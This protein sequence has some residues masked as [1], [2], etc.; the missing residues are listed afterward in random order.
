VR[1][2]VL[3]LPSCRL[4]GLC[5]GV[6]IQVVDTRAWLSRCETVRYARDASGCTKA[7]LRGHTGISP[8]QFVVFLVRH[9]CG[10]SAALPELVALRLASRAD[11]GR[12][13]PS[14]GS[15]WHPPRFS[16]ASGVPPCD[17]RLAQ[18]APRSTDTRTTSLAIGGS[19]PAAAQPFFS[20]RRM[21]ARPKSPVASFSCSFNRSS[22]FPSSRR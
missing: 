12:S 15:T 19:H 2:S 5:V 6:Q 11:P 1:G 13:S 16:G 10:T 18:P 17:H 3:H 20:R 7:L 22:G 8:Y 9:N 4:Q 14:Q 21:I